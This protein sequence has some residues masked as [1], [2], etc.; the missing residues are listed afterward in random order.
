MTYIRSFVF[1]IFIAFWTLL[2]GLIGPITILTRKQKVV[3]YI[4]WLW[5]Y[6]VIKGLEIIC[7]VRTKVLNAH[8]IPKTGCIV[9]SK[10]QS[11]WETIFFLQY[12]FNPAFVL[13]KE[14]QRI[15]IYGW[16]LPMLEMISINRKGGISIIKQMSQ[17]A[18]KAFSNGRNIIIFPEGTRVAV[19]QSVEYKSG[20][21]ALHKELPKIK[22][23]PVA[24]NSGKIWPRK[25]WLI[26]SGTITVKFLSP[27]TKPMLKD[28]L[29][30]KLKEEIDSATNSL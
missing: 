28:Q 9:A 2:I 12:F 11:A 21:A 4:G 8:L 29:L 18:I 16:Y 3:A 5:A 13:K 24:L 1:I 20:I 22:I 14:L 30:K 27:I 17:S 26:S 25:S 19:N 6:F 7:G 23:L 15:P 10:H